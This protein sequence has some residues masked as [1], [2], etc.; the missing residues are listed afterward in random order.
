MGVITI[1][2]K[3]DGWFAD[4]LAANPQ[5]PAPGHDFALA[6]EWAKRGWEGCLVEIQQEALV[7]QLELKMRELASLAK[8]FPGE[9][10]EIAERIE[11]DLS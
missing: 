2:E 9:F 10:R 8:V 6:L 1:Q 7:E 3:F 11:K 5:E 4:Q